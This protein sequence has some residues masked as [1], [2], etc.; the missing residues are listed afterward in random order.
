MSLDAWKML[1]FS[2]MKVAVPL[3]P[4][5][6]GGGERRGAGWARGRGGGGGAGPMIW[7]GGLQ[8]AGARPPA[9]LSSRGP[10]G[11]CAAARRLTWRA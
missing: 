1:G 4:V 7:R 3:T 9:T 8:R 2:K 11:G 10:G 5:L 6:R